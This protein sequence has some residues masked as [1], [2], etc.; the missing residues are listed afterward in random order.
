MRHL[1]V[2]QVEAVIILLPLLPD[3]HR[4]TKANRPVR[5]GEIMIG[6]MEDRKWLERTGKIV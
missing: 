2:S 1:A 4:A 6:V 3:P 5:T